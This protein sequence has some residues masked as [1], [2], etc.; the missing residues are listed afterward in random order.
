MP[1]SHLAR[2]R[3][4]SAAALLTALLIACA[5][6][7]VTP[8]P[9]VTPT[10]TSTPDPTPVPGPPDPAPL[11]WVEHTASPI[12]LYEGQG[13]AVNGRLYV[14]GGFDKNVD[15]QPI[16]TRA[17]HVYDP[18]TDQWATLNDIPDAVTHAGVA[19][20]GTVLYVAGGF[21][22]NHPGPQTDHVWKY[23]TTADHWTAMP[24]L[25]RARGAGA[26]VRLGRELHYFGGTERTADGHYLQD[27][28]DHLVLS[29]DAPTTWRQAAPLPNP[30]NHLGG[31]VLGGMIY[32]VGGQH[33]G[34]EA[35]SD[36]TDVD[37]YD[38]AT[39]TWTAVASLPMPLGHITASTIVLG[40]RLV[41]VGGVTLATHAGANEGLESDE[42][43]AYDPATDQ[44]APLTS[45]P[46]PRQSPVADVIA[47]TLVVTT[48]S[49]AEGPVDNTWTGH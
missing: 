40:S 47:N 12:P 44:W 21:M 26:L 31:A 19:V 22:G 23:D 11:S 1:S 42:V 45:L 28:G 34:N 39:D 30:R 3:H 33:L 35:Y 25:P 15:G 9:Q 5:G 32:A 37:R 6:P 4:W 38:P 2:A 48:G 16:A 20:D 29:L 43:T 13:A 46:G 24:P 49:T 7:T 10:P 27:D 8:T 36:Q 14:F 17:A 18:A 41:V